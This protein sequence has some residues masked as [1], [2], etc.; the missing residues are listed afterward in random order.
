MSCN[1]R[2]TW[3]WE[4]SDFRF[5]TS[6]L[7]ASPQARVCGTKRDAAHKN[8]NVLAMWKKLFSLCDCVPLNMVAEVGEMFPGF[9]TVEDLANRNTGH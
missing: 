5:L 9:E 3:L 8:P 1:L 6:G 7:P 4:I 2:R